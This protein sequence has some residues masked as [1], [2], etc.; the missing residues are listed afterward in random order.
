MA[1]QHCSEKNPLPHPTQFHK[2]E[3]MCTLSSEKVFSSWKGFEDRHNKT[4]KTSFFI[5]LE[6]LSAAAHNS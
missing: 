4:K 5:P 2:R 6:Y 1:F 3:S